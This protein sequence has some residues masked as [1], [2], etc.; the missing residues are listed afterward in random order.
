[1][2]ANMLS[3][4]LTATTQAY[5][6]FDLDP[7]CVTASQQAGFTVSY[8]D[9]SRSDVLKAAG[10]RVCACSRACCVRNATVARQLQALLRLHLNPNL[11]LCCIAVLLRVSCVH[12]SGTGV[13][14]P[15]AVIICYPTA[16]ATTKAVESIRSAYSTVPIYACAQSFK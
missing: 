7:A 14:R 1:M 5:I 4:P 13:N 2:V 10:A 6:G 9:G 12:V 11:T 15:A 8:G 16:D 3:S